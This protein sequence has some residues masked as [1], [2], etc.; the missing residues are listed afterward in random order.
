MAPT[1]PSRAVRLTGA[2][3]VASAL[4]VPTAA[5]QDYVGPPEAVGDGTEGEG[6]VYVGLPPGLP[7]EG[8]YVGVPPAD[9]DGSHYVGAGG[10]ASGDAGMSG[11]GGRP[12]SLA[13]GLD[14]DGRPSLARSVSAGDVAA[15]GGLA[16]A[17][18]IATVVAR[19]RGALRY[20]RPFL[21]L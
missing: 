2:A 7:G 20:R 17:A 15:I 21:P 13:G 18:A 19:R 11:T 16:A 5:A 6:G 1:T 10:P 14:E 12:A 4:Y 8:D 3:M 9:A